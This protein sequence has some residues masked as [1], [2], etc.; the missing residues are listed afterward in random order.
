MKP[1]YTFFLETKQQLLFY[2]KSIIVFRLVI[3]LGKKKNTLFDRKTKINI[4]E[5]YKTTMRTVCPKSLDP[6]PIVNY[7]KYGQDFLDKQKK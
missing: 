7:Y 5:N 1:P 3:G 2:K 4:C 6:F